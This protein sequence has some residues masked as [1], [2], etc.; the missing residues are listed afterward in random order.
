MAIS[1]DAIAIVASNLTVARC[2]LVGGFA[3]FTD[4][5]KKVDAETVERLFAHYLDRLR[6]GETSHL[7][8]P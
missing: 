7:G 4:E 8:S 2:A 6:T 3:E 1:E 5:R